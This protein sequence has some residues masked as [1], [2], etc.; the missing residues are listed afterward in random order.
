MYWLHSTHEVGLSQ[1]YNTC[2][3]PIDWN[4]EGTL[5]LHN[6]R[7]PLLSKRPLKER[8]RPHCTLKC[9]LSRKSKDQGEITDGTTT[10]KKKIEQAD[11]FKVKT[12]LLE[13]K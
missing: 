2:C 8:L 1:F 13:P 11:C 4:V 7:H 3:N 6:T 10:K 5:R 12:E 9:L